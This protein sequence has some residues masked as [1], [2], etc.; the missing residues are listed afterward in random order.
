VQI[1]RIFAGSLAAMLMSGFVLSIS[2]QA[3]NST[4][5]EPDWANPLTVAIKK[6]AP[7][8]SSQDEPNFLNNLDCALITYHE[9]ASD[10][11]QTGC[12]SST[13]IGWLDSDSG[14]TIFN[15]SDEGLSLQTY[16]SHQILVPWPGALDMVALDPLSTGGTLVSLYKNPLIKLQ[17][18]RN[19]IG[20]LTAKRLTEPPELPIYDANGDQLVIN[21]QTIAFSS[22]G[23]W[24]VAESLN[25]SFLRINL[26]TLDETAF[27]QA[28]GSLG[29]PALLKSRVAISG[30]GRFIAIEMTW[31]VHSRFMI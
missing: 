2:A 18:E 31:R 13:A 1:R 29:S 12:F 5:D 4:T 3:N 17:D 10:T 26:A 21:P 25:G 7:L 14:T 22:N 15:G 24:L 19:L 23:S 28:Y 20:Q 8:P 6:A 30:S 16:T 27:A 9:P 11:G